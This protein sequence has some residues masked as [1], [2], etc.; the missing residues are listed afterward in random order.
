MVQGHDAVKNATSVLDFVFRAL[1]YEYLDR[2]DL[3]H[4][5]PAEK[6]T[7]LIETQHGMHAV[8]SLGPVDGATADTKAPTQ[9]GQHGVRTKLDERDVKAKKARLQGY[10]GEQCGCG[11]MRVRRNGTCTVCEDCGSTSGCS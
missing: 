9:P 7:R 4:V 10:T 5:Q 11:S 8:A 3:V 1:A 6:Q 2:D